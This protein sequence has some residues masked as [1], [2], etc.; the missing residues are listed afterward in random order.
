MNILV[1]I[2]GNLE[3]KLD[4]I[5]KKLDQMPKKTVVGSEATNQVDKL[6]GSTSRLESSVSGMSTKVQ[7][8]FGNIKTAAKGL[9]DSIQ[10]MATSIAGITI[11]GAVSGIDWMDS[12]K[13]KLYNEQIKEAIENNKKLGLTYEQLTKF[14]EEQ[15]AAGE[16]TRQDTAKEL[17]AVLTAGSKFTGKGQKGLEAADAITDFY[18]KH[19][20]S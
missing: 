1:E 6:A 15:A 8:A 19:R 4:A 3:A 13:T 12:A 20:V 18:F 16:G 5:N 14:S 7:S 10:Q 17:Y 2:A 9:Q 11:G